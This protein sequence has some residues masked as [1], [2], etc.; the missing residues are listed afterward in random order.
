MNQPIYPR[1]VHLQGITVSHTRILDPHAQPPAF[2]ACDD[3]CQWQQSANHRARSANS[4]LMAF[5]RNFWC[6][7]HRGIF[8]TATRPPVLPETLP[9][10]GN[11]TVIAR[12]HRAVG[13]GRGLAYVSLF[14]TACFGFHIALVTAERISVAI[15]PI[16]LVLVVHT[17]Y[18]CL[19]A[20]E[21]YGL[22][23]QDL[24]NDY[25]TRMGEMSFVGNF[26]ASEPI[27]WPSLLRQCSVSV[28]ISH[29]AQAC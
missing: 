28:V 24:C 4:M 20:L 13:I 14:C 17:V 5:M 29:D 7:V 21:Y 12:A 15:A 16:P 11:T 1:M 9:L 6:A 23:D 3:S 26:F 10:H 18:L 22:L 19:Y 8:P 2:F 27:A 25:T